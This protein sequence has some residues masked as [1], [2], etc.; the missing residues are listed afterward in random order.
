M[1]EDAEEWG[2]GEEPRG[3]RMNRAATGDW[4]LRTEGLRGPRAHE[5]TGR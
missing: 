3:A 2:G 5:V 4:G 1:R